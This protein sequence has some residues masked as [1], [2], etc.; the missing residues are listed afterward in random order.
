MKD[1]NPDHLPAE[2]IADRLSAW[3]VC[4][5]GHKTIRAWGSFF[6]G[7]EIIYLDEHVVSERRSIKKDSNHT[8]MDEGNIYRVQY[9][10]INQITGKLECRFYKNQTLL[11]ASLMEFKKGFTIK[12]I[13]FSAKRAL[14]I[15]LYAIIFAISY[16]AN[17]FSVYVALLLFLVFTTL[18]LVQ[19][20]MGKW[21]IKELPS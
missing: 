4:R 8:F 10:L 16:F 5:D 21:V 17:V 3:F 20:K 6:T 13:P 7:K 12:S 14:L 2:S 19:L 9:H 11:K 1:H 15:I 18:Q